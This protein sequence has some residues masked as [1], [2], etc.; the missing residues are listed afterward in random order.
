MLIRTMLVGAMAAMRPLMPFG[1]LVGIPGGL[2]LRRLSRA[3]G[4]RDRWRLLI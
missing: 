3:I 4:Y 1:P 2:L